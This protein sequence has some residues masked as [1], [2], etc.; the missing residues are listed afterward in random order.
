MRQLFSVPLLCRRLI[1]YVGTIRA[2]PKRERGVV[3]VGVAGGVDIPRIIRVAAI[4]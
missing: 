1:A 3:V 2:A 4:R